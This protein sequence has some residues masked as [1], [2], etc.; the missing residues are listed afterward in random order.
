[1]TDP[2]LQE[3][4]SSPS[5]DSSIRHK[6]SNAKSEGSAS[7]IGLEHRQN[8][9]RMPFGLDIA[10]DVRDAPLLVDYKG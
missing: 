9:L 2:M 3:A 7:S 8:F 6:R 5:V 4:R 10:K 1:M